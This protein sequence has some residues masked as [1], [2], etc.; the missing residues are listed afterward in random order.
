MHS[1]C[2]ICDNPLPI[3]HEFYHSG[4]LVIGQI[5]AHILMM[6]GSPSFLELPKETLIKE[7]ISVIKYYQYLLALVFAV[8]EMNESPNILPNITL[9]FHI[10]N[11]YYLP[12]MMYKVTLSLLTA[13]QS[14]VPN[15]MCDPQK[16]LI[17]AI[18]GLVSE[19]TAN[20]AAI[21]SIYNI[22][23]FSYGSFSPV[24][25]DKMLFSS[26]YQMVPNEDY[27][28]RGI[29]HLLQYFR[30]TWIGLISVDNDNGDRFLQSVVPLLSQ[31]KICYSFVL[32]MPKRTYEDE[33]FLMFYK[34]QAQYLVLVKSKATVYFVY[35]E[36][37]SLHILRMLLSLGE[38]VSL[39]LP[40]KIWVVTSHWEFES[41]SIEKIWDTE[42]FH[43]AISFAVHS[44][45]PPGFQKFLQNIR[46]SWATGDGFIQ[47]FWEQAF[48]CLLM[49]YKKKEESKTICTGEEK[50]E[51]LPGIL[52][53]MSMTGHSYNVYNAAYAVAHALHDIY[54]SRYRYRRLVDGREMAFQNV[55]PWQLHQ[56]LRSMSFNNSAGDTVH[57][58]ENGELVEGFD[59]INWVTFPNSSFVRV[60]VGQLD[61]R[62][63]EGKDLM[64]NDDLIVWHRSFNQVLPISVCNDPCHPGSS[65]KKKEGEKF[66]CYDCV[67]CPQGMI[68]E[69]ED[70]DACVKCPEELYPNHY[71]SQCIPKDVSYLSYK[72]MLG[73]VLII[74]ATSFS[75]LTA[76]VLGII[77][78]NRATP[79]VK[80]SNRHLTY[81][82]LISLILCFLCSFLFIGQPAKVTCLIQQ[83]AFGTTFSVALS[84]VLA[85]TITV[86]LAFVATKP[87]SGMRNWVGKRVANLVVFCCSFIQAAICIIWLSTSPPFLY[88]DMQSLNGE[89]I[90]EC[91]AGSAAM[92]YCALGYL[93]FLAVVSFIVAFLARKLPDSF[94]EAKFITFSMLVFCSVW[95]CFIPTYFST[96][97]KYMVAVEIFSILASSAGLLV[98]IFSP[99][100]YIIILRPELNNKLQLIKRKN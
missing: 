17:A 58:K 38:L 68:S 32:R 5:V 98:C 54:V 88:M 26:L 30:W 18:G 63:P 11:G 1:Q 44:N 90:L 8:K 75:L 31:N 20:M 19:T 57:F 96:K 23:Q 25:D 2:D 48:S 45:Q 84:S 95:L 4:D 59:I 71:Q 65:R 94:N 69:Q 82:L 89:I 42:A 52:F 55:P 64:L 28:F 16:K 70:V 100:C 76:F 80:A 27:Q 86:V 93:G 10:L 12:R 13:H 21:L 79:I 51:S 60:K 9:G 61:P 87:G 6:H 97:G 72:E 66:C 34:F 40:G 50:L 39:P 49:P 74:L 83:T 73:I 78:K 37:P 81:V 99:K 62:A 22:P 85:K 33:A 67:P 3:A 36:A 92:F 56:F 53:E 24:Q 29:V 43:G 41:L 35:G 7:P 14:F 47:E 77:I 46:P 91:R 15:F